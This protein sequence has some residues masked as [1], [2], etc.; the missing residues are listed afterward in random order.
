MAI[1]MKA[2]AESPSG[3]WIT[4]NASMVMDQVVNRAS[5]RRLAMKAPIV[6]PLQNCPSPTV[7]T[8]TLHFRLEPSKEPKILFRSQ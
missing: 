8:D 1:L 7:L 4:T 5:R 2:V 6:V 3:N